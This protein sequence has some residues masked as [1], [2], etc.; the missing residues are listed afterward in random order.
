MA[1]L[2]TV[3]DSACIHIVNTLC[4]VPVAKVGTTVL[5]FI[6]CILPLYIDLLQGML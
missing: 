6:H 1:V 3:V 4:I 2:F 5:D